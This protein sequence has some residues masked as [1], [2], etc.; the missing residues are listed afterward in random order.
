[1][2]AS[3]PQVLYMVLILP[4]MFGL[5]LVGEGI[6]KLTQNRS[7]GWFNIAMGLGF[8]ATV[9]GGFLMLSGAI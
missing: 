2:K 3:D 8:I 1:M 5:T 4:A 9:L 7:L 6:Y